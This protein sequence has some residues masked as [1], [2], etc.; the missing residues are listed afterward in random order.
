[1]LA[2]EY[3]R[4]CPQGPR[5]PQRLGLFW[6]RKAPGVRENDLLAGVFCK[7]SILDRGP[8]LGKNSFL[9]EQHGNVVENKGPL[10][11]TRRKAGMFMKRKVLSP[12]GRNVVGKTGCYRSP[13]QERVTAMDNLSIAAR[14]MA[15]RVFQHAN[16]C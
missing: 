13:E 12:K 5:T 16:E 8:H 14:F 4:E 6:K 11:K 3:G 9:N 7:V 10:W 2:Y 1:M 15:N